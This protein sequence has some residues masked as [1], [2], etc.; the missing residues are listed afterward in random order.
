MNTANLFQ[1][2]FRDE[3]I[4]DSQEIML[5][6]CVSVVSSIACNKSDPDTIGLALSTAQIFVIL[7][8]PCLIYT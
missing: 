1:T 8:E 3:H 7:F 4:K 6:L 2:V 5:A